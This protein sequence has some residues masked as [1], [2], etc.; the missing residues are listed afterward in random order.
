[1]L[2][3]RFEKKEMLMLTEMIDKNI[4]GALLYGITPP[5]E[6]TE[7]IK[8]K[9]TSEKRNNRI[10][11]LA[12]DALVVYDIQDESNRTNEKRPFKYFPTLNPLDYTENYH[13]NVNC[14]KIIY[15][16]VGKYSE[17]ELKNRIM[18][19]EQNNYLSVFVGASS[20]N[21]IS[22]IRLEEAYRIHSSLSN[23][24]YL[25]G[26]VIP[27]RHN[28]KQ[29]EH[30]RIINKQNQGCSFFI[31]QCIC[32]IELIKNFISD[33]C[34]S[35]N[36]LGMKKGYFVFTLTICGTVETLDLMNWLG[37]D[38]PKWLKND[39]IRSK[40]IIDESIKQNLKIV[41]EL[42]EYCAI[43]GLNCGFN[44]E[45]VSPKKT[46]VDASVLLFNEAKRIVSTYKYND[47]HEA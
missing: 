38:I 2:D 35:I 8:L 28:N 29:D 6:N 17:Q 37:I 44:I 41:G 11:S 24:K 25:G 46:E 27:E 5:K 39:L 1:M 3:V 36:E 16:V 14:Q 9:E 31:S 40:D 30:L 42:I 4:T 18:L 45:S 32:N 20:K 34:I 7:P 19:C 43:K 10:N 12:C 21:Q 15:H 26:I 23:Q 22:R 33:Y 47:G 13:K